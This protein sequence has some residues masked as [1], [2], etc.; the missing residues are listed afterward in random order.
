MS[1]TNGTRLNRW[2]AERGVSSRR[3]ADELIRDG[4]VAINGRPVTELGVRVQPGDKVTVDGRALR[5]VPK[6]YF[7]FYKPKGVLCTDDPRENRPRV[8]DLVERQVRARVYPI[9]RLDEESEGLLL[10]TN[11]GDFAN[12]IAHPR[13]RVPRTYVVKIGGEL[14]Q[15]A[16]AQLRG[17]VRLAEG[18]IVPNRVRIIHETRETTTVEVVVREGI[19]REIRRMFAKLGFKVRAL[20]RVRIGPVGLTGVR[21]GLVRPLTGEERE[22]LMALAESRGELPEPPPRPRRRAR[23]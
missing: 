1:A 11:D 18:K 7:A 17:G 19:N 21:R 14:K 5:D 23:R 10:L 9:G 15:E 4:L 6:L 13:Y 2:L 3:K 8:R 22:G 12:R 16:L 20:K